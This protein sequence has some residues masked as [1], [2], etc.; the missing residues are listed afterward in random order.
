MIDTL[1]LLLWDVEILRFAFD[2]SGRDVERCRSL[3]EVPI[4]LDALS[5]VE[6]PISEY[7][8]C[9]ISLLLCGLV[10]A[11]GPV[12]LRLPLTEKLLAPVLTP[13]FLVVLSLIAILPG[14]DIM[15]VESLEALEV[16]L[17][18]SSSS[19]RL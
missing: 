1:L 5:D 8:C 14:L 12:V 9:L 4:L 18:L 13:I 19:L 7:N 16:S 2:C 17:S 3:D 6:S 11:P 15:T 10:D